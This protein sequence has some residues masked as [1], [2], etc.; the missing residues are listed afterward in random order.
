M[1]VCV[2]LVFLVVETRNTRSGLLQGNRQLRQQIQNSIYMAASNNLELVNAVIRANKFLSPEFGEGYEERAQGWGLSP[3][4]YWKVIHHYR[5]EF[6]YIEDQYFTPLPMTD[7]AAIDGQFLRTM[8]A[9][10]SNR[11]WLEQKHHFH[12]EFVTYCDNLIEKSGV[13]I[14]SLRADYRASF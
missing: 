5:A 13:S 1:S 2:T 10:S 6:G 7:R 12:T 3:E 11:F 8:R 9:P 4:D 14:G